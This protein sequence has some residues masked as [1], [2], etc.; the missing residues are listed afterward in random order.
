MV[1]PTKILTQQKPLS[2]ALKAYVH[3]DLRDKGWIKV[4]LNPAA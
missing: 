2:D 3:F 4:A 1:D